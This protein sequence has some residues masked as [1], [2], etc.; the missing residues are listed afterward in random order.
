MRTVDVRVADLGGGWVLD[1]LADAGGALA[2]R[3]PRVSAAAA[4]VAWSP[5]ACM[6]AMV[7]RMVSWNVASALRSAASSSG[8]LPWSP[9][10]PPGGSLEEDGGAAAP[11]AAAPLEADAS[12]PP[13]S[14]FSMFSK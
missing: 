7:R 12:C 6:R 3:P 2:P 4:A 13:P 9:N 11:A 8:D 10:A 1:G 14:S 5:E